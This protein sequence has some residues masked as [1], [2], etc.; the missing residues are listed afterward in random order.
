MRTN[1]QL[2]R[3]FFTAVAAGE[4]PDSL[5]TP[6]M[7]A[8]TTTQ[9]AMDKAAYQHVITLLAAISAA[10]LTFTID[11][12]TA[13]DDRAVAELRSEGALLNGE[14]YAN[15]YAFTFRFQDGRIAAVAE[16]FNPL[17]VQEKMIPLVKAMRGKAGE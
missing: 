14:P 12:I 1:H 11:C 17:I 2:V 8:W 5:L 13:E 15:T 6:D 16:H 3:D 4:L 7:T 10:P 9:G